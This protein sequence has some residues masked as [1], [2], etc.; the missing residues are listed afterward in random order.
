MILLEKIFMWIGI[1]IVGHFV[2]GFITAL[3]NHFIDSGYEDPSERTINFFVLVLIGY[4]G[5]VIL[6]ITGAKDVFKKIKEKFLFWR[7]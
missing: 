3:I 2:V 4:M 7:N 6:I 1:V 5:A